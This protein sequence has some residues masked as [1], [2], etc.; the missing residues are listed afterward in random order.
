MVQVVKVEGVETIDSLLNKLPNDLSEI[1]YD[2]LNELI[3]RLS[4]IKKE[5][6]AEQLKGCWKEFEMCA[7]GIGISIDEAIDMCIEDDNKTTKKRSLRVKYKDPENPN[8][9]WA[10]R[11]KLPIWLKDYEAAGR[12]RSEFKV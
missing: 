7:E 6:D 10:G 12:D 8:N 1:P 11:G 9:S 4:I 3:G 2:Q 5:H